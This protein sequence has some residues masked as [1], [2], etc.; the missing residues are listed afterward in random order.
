M[1]KQLFLLPLALGGMFVIGTIIYSLFQSPQFEISRER[2]I[3]SPPAV[4]FDQVANLKNW[5]NWSPWQ[6]SDPE[7]KITY[8]GAERGTGAQ[9]TWEG[10]KSGR[11]ELV[12]TDFQE[13]SKLRYKIT[14]KDWEST[15]SGTFLITPKIEDGKTNTHVKWTMKG[16][17]RFSE[18]LLWLVFRFKKSIEKDFDAGLANLEQATKG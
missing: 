17:N 8:Q 11:G 9:F 13:G 15:S 2:I 3:P 14:F 6:K 4:V 18:R 12:V 5:K 1:K 10:P 16:E 7:A